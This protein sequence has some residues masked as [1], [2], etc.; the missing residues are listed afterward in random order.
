MK[1]P[2]SINVDCKEYGIKTLKFSME[3]GYEEADLGRVRTK[4]ESD[5]PFY[6]KSLFL[7]TH[8]MTEEVQG[9]YD[10]DAT[11][12]SHKFEIEIDDFDFS[13]GMEYLSFRIEFLDS[14]SQVMCPVFD[15][16]FHGLEINH[17]QPVF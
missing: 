14:E 10:F 5:W 17:H 6:W 3:G 8:E 12:E 11:F 4:L 2:E 7:T 9:I 13:D 15:T 16:C 1:P